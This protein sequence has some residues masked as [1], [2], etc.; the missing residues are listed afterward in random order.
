MI[1]NSVKLPPNIG[2]QLTLSNGVQVPFGAIVALAGDYYGVPDKPIIDIEAVG[3][4][5][6]EPKR[7]QRFLAAY[8]TLGLGTGDQIQVNKL[9]K[10]IKEDQKA[11]V[12]GGTLHTNAEWDEAT[13]GSWRLGVPVTYGTMMKLAVKNFDHFQPQATQAYLVGH[14]LAIE[15]AREAAKEV[16]SKVKMQKLMQAYSMEAFAGHYLT[17]GFSAGHIRFDVA[18]DFLITKIC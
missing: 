5:T 7:R 1:G 3:T 15:K 14:A 2:T 10:M 12:S 9:V 11:K 17:D 6:D 8:G 13:G 4:N 16:D 18:N